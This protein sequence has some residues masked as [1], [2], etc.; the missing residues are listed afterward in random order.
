MRNWYTE[1]K[2]LLLTIVVVMMA[3]VGI[4]FYFLLETTEHFLKNRD[5]EV[6]IIADNLNATLKSADTA[7]KS[8]SDLA[9]KGKAV[10]TQAE[11]MVK[12]QASYQASDHEKIDNV[13]DQSETALI[14]LQRVAEDINDNQKKLSDAVVGQVTHLGPLVEAATN[15]VNT[16]GATLAGPDVQGTLHNIDTTMAHVS[17]TTDHLDHVAGILAQKVDDNMKPQPWWRKS[18]SFMYKAVMLAS[19]V[20]DLTGK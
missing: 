20:R 10:V 2:A 1:L 9:E 15:T 13:L 17:S 5:A 19:G 6:A 7:V 14:N 3:F 12:T 16:A 8:I 18:L 4:R 11:G